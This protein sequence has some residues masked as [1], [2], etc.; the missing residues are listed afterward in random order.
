MTIECYYHWCKHHDVHDDPEGGPFCYEDEC[1]ATKTELTSF[2]ILRK[3]ELTINKENDMLT[4]EFDTKNLGEELQV[5]N[6]L[7][8]H[9]REQVQIFLK[10]GNEDEAL[11]WDVMA[12]RVADDIQKLKK[13]G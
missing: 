13:R 8:S 6:D 5:L 7:E 2:A 3:E 9:Y 11:K 4:E 12:N 10:E 1:R